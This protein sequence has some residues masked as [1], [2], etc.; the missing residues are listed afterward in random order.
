MIPNE[1]LKQATD[2]IC[3]FEGFYPNA[4]R[5]VGGIWTIGYGQI[6]IAGG[7]PVGQW[8]TITKAESLAFVHKRVKEI[9]KFIIERVNRK[10]ENHQYSA[11]IS[12]VYNVG[13]GAFARS[14]L[15][16]KINL[17][18]SKDDICKEFKRW[19]YVKG[20]WIKGLHNRRIKET[21]VYF[22]EKIGHLKFGS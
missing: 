6:T 3:Q 14:T 18:S 16:K 22:P 11:L 8:D 1:I 13:Q 17:N 9:Y 4:Y 15:L 21:Q 12:F 7:R 5:D 19:S 10:L 20:K 2:L